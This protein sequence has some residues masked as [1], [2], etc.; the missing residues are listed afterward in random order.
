[1]PHTRLESWQA[2]NVSGD[3]SGRSGRHIE[4]GAVAVAF[5]AVLLLVSL[6]LPWYADRLTAWSVFEVMDLL[7]AAI[8]IAALLAAAR[9]FGA[10]E[11]VPVRLLPYLGAAALVIIVGAILNHPPAAYGQPPDIGIWLA[12]V[13]ALVLVGGAVLSEFGVSLSIR[14][15]RRA[16]LVRPS[17]APLGSPQPP[18]DT[19]A[20]AN[21]EDSSDSAGP[22]DST[23][24]Q[25]PAEPD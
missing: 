2:V 6:F 13:G 9:R 25:E 22:D 10:A 3:K 19:A 18:A 23:V 24:R 11:T 4:A 1:M 20:A 12:L 17:S 14:F 8:A 21:G 15:E 7:L 5:G 16:G